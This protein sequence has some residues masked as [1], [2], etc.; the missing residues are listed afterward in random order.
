MRC[1]SARR[2]AFTLIEM[3]VVTIIIGI[4]IGLV[5]VAVMSAIERA[6][7][8]VRYN[9][10]RQM[11]N[12]LQTMSTGYA[13]FP[14]ANLAVS[15]DD[16]FNAPVAKWFA[17][18]YPRYIQGT[19]PTARVAILRADLLAAGAPTTFDP[20]FAL[21]FWLVGFDPDSE[22][23]L[24]GHAARMTGANRKDWKFEF[25]PAR[26]LNKRYLMPGGGALFDD[27]NGNSAPDLATEKYRAYI[28]FDSGSYGTPYA[29][30]SPYK[31]GAAATDLYFDPDT[32]QVICAGRD[33]VLGS[34]GAPPGPA[35]PYSGFDSDNIASFGGGNT[36]LDFIEKVK[37]Q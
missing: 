17:R 36:M 4:L 3:L 8:T 29:G 19:S 16:D 14:P 30:F 22:H 20:S 25:D 2:S 34:G 33:N 11:A 13:S 24:N 32:C 10:A 12:A 35:V 21:V 31:I 6:K 1:R 18:N 15:G 23:P 27:K 37:N 26:L 5:S 7:N 9:E 28:Y